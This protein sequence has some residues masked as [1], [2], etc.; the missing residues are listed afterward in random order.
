M[1]GGVL[2]LAGRF[3]A[4]HGFEA[5]FR[6][7]RFVSRPTDVATR[8]W[9]PLASIQ[10]GP[11]LLDRF[12]IDWASSCASLTRDHRTKLFAVIDLHW[13]DCNHPGFLPSFGDAEFGAKQEIQADDLLPLG[14]L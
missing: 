12:S 3:S 10:D 6:G 5:V 9:L 2:P 11:I 13:D 4:A 14:R 8:G 1:N 7:L